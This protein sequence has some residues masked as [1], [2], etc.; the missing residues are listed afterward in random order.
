VVAFGILQPVLL[1]LGIKVRA[2]RLEI[3]GIALGVLMDVDAVLAGWKIVQAELEDY[4]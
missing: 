3:G 2:G 1:A 4:P